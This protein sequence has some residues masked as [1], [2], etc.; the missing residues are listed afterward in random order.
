MQ[1]GTLHDDL[2]ARAGAGRHLPEQEVLR[3]FGAVCEG[4]RCM[5]EARP[6]LAHRDLKTAN[7]LLTAD[8]EPVIMDLGQWARL[9][10]RRGALV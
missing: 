5:H 8:R 4:V 7:V 9:R 1:G 2:S 10:L 3:L 6:P